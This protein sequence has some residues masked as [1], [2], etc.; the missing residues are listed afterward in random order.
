MRQWAI[1]IALFASAC[2]NLADAPAPQNERAAL[3]IAHRGASGA[4]PEHTLE[5]YVRA[6]ELGA[7]FIE[8]DLVMT[9]DGVL[10]ARHDPWL[11]ASTDISVR[12]EFADRKS[13]V[14]GP[15]GEELTDW[16]AWDFTLDELKTLRA[17]QVRPGR[18][19]DFDDLWA[20][21]TYDEIA[22]LAAAEQDRTGRVIGLYPETKW[23]RHHHDRGLDMTAATE[24]ALRRHGHEEADAPV[25]VQSF[26]PFILLAL[27]Q[28]VN[29]RLVQLVYP[30]GSEAGAA[31]NVDLEVLA[32][33]ASGV[34]PHKALVNDPATGAPTGYAARARAIGL[35]VHP[36]T[37]RDDDLPDWATSPEDE[38][39]AAIRA[40]ATGFFTDFPGTGQ[41]AVRPRPD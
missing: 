34:G 3:I 25:F 2:V 13:T 14:T 37:F 4:L 16:F 5:A 33:Y 29:T 6:I 24:A 30:L 27:K 23:P 20:I 28:R 39:R 41:I 8:P 10:V 32:R 26:E 31:H 17:R 19:G 12:P 35:E 21:P 9:R 40:G 36:W 18:P 11:S 22:E 38:I 15:A 1:V 7:D